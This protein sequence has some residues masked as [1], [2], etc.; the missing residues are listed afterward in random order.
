MIREKQKEHICSKI[1]IADQFVVAKKWKLK[2]EMEIK[3]MPYNWR[4]VKQILAD[5]C[6]GI[7]LHHEK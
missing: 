7:L 1:F 3:T 5:Y 4:I 6:D 2:Q